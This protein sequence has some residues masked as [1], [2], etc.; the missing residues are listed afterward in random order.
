MR[1]DQHPKWTDTSD[2]R[3]E[4]DR[5]FDQIAERLEQQALEYARRREPLAERWFADVQQFEGRYPDSVKAELE[6]NPASSE[7]FVNMTRPKVRVLASRLADILFP[8]DD[9]NWEIKPSAEPEIPLQSG[10][11]GFQPAAQTTLPVADRPADVPPDAMPPPEGGGAMGPQGGAETMPGAPPG[12]APPTPGANEE[13]DE[14]AVARR[15]AERMGRRMKDQLEASNYADIGAKILHQGAMLGNGVIKG[16]V[17]AEDRRVWNAERK[18]FEMKRDPRPVFAWVDLWNFFPD[19]DA[20]TVEE[21][22]S[23]F[24][25]HRLS[26]RELRKLAKRSDFNE[27]NIRD[28]LKQG[29]KFEAFLNYVDETRE[30]RGEIVEQAE[31]RFYAWEFHGTLERKELVAMARGMEDADI[32]K[33]YGEG[34]PLDMIDVIVWVCQGRVLK[35]GPHPL[36]GAHHLYSVWSLDL[37]G[38]SMFKDGVSA[39]LRDPQIALNAA[40][41]ITMQAAALLGVPMFVIDRGVKPQRG[42]RPRIGPGEIFERETPNEHAGLIPVEINAQVTELIRVIEVARQFMDDESNLPLVAHGDQSAESKTAHGMSLL[43]NAVNIVFRDA[44]RAFDR[45]VTIPTLRRLYEWNMMNLGDDDDDLVG[46][47]DIK[48]RGSSILLVRDIQAQNLMM[49]LNLAATNPVISQILKIPEAF[50]KLMQ[51]MQLSKD[52]MILTDD[53]LRDLADALAQEGDPETEAKIAIE[54]MKLQGQLQI[55]EMRFRTELLKLAQQGELSMQQ[56][57]ADLEKVRM[58]TQSKE[59]L[60]AAEFAVKERHGTGI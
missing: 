35:F 44:T 39:M 15:A 53:E 50:R 5:Q 14:L 26:A 49:V 36:D 25:L 37:E 56:I 12:I 54:Q 58:Q 1:L 51:A 4:K 27:A 11:R 38:T 22:D 33:G 34:D 30:D 45:Q 28:V 9:S 16:P 43:A 17:Q 8:T 20:T 32:I 18:E 42:G 47:M 7:L 52:E 10:K 48:A 19:P 60:T 29:P 41:R 6:A 3:S 24:E 55:E 46:D 13:L 57:M 23:I 2:A 59:R 40:W 21:C 31:T